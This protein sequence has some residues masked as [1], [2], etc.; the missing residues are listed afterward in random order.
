MR[1]ALPASLVALALAAPAWAGA[2]EFSGAFVQGGLVQ[3]RA[4]PGAT[5]ALDG[6]PVRVSPEGVFLLGFGRDAAKAALEVTGPAGMRET[7]VLAIAKR[8]FDVQ[9]IDGL[10]EAFVTPPPE[11]EA[12]I[13]EEGELV[14]RARRLDDARTDF[15]QGFAWP[16]Q[17]RISG[18]YGS[19]RILNGKP[20]APHYGVDIAGPV[21]TPVLAPAAGVVT[22]AADLYFTGWTV[23]LDHGH[24]LSSVF[25]HMS[26]ATAKVGQRLGRGEQLGRLGA[27]GRAT[28]PHLHWGMNLFDVRLD[29]QLLVPPMPR[30]AE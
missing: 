1:R 29:P 11:I 9:K 30:P 23:I 4:E 24:G 20:R 28:G 2:P 14:D 7:R 16:V 6:R 22:L 19:Q 17:G 15:L 10:P 21:G 8:K 26:E 25:M 12:R 5:V 27:T 3:G 18:V 13:K